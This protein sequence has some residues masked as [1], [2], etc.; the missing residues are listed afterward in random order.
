M[1]EAIDQHMEVM[2]KMRKRL[3]ENG[4]D[5]S[6]E[7]IDPDEAWNMEFS[8]WEESDDSYYDENNYN[9]LEVN[10]KV[11]DTVKLNSSDM[12]MTIKSIDN[13]MLTCRWFDKN[14]ILQS[15]EFGALEINLI[16]KV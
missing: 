15:E 16:D 2:E 7:E 11:G 8:S 5:V 9:D 12:P 3:A 6:L 1:G 4:H 10:F 13:D 14:Y